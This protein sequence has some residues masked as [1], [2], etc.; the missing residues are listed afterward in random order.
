MQLKPPFPVPA[1]GMPRASSGLD[2]SIR[3]SLLGHA[4]E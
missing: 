4:L 1:S 3:K 2:V